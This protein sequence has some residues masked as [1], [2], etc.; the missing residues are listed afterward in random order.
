MAAKKKK[1]RRGRP[2]GPPEN[3]RRRVFLI[4]LT[5]AELGVFTGAARAAGESAADWARREL[6]V[7][8]MRPFGGQVG[9]IKN[10]DGERR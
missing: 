10:G 1:L 8:A 2:P 6:M 9:G 7:A 4:R 5:D 3:V